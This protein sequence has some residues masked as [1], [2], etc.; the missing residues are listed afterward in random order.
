MKYQVCYNVN[1]KIGCVADNI[2]VCADNPEGD[3]DHEGALEIVKEC[4]FQPLT[5]LKFEEV[6]TRFFANGGSEFE[7]AVSGTCMLE[8]EAGSP[9]EAKLKANEIMMKMDFGDLEDK[10]IAYD[11]VLVNMAEVAELDDVELD[12]F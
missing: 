4:D 2:N 9:E 12:E 1:G 3:L 6:H 10:D 11:N 5:D 7:F 8:I